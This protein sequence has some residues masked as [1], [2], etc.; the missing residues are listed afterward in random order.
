MDDSPS[1]SKYRILPVVV[2]CVTPPGSSAGRRATRLAIGSFRSRIKS[3][4]GSFTPPN[5]MNAVERLSGDHAGNHWFPFLTDHGVT[6]S[7]GSGDRQRNPNI[8]TAAT[9]APAPHHATAHGRRACCAGGVGAAIDASDGCAWTGLSE[10][11]V[12][13]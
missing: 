11:A 2:H 9:T 3:S 10:C 4:G 12:S 13:S 8:T 1:L 6:R 7:G 5:A